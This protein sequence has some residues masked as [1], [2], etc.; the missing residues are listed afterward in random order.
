MYLLMADGEQGSGE[1]WIATYSDDECALT[2]SSRILAAVLV[3][4]S[5]WIEEWWQR[6][7]CYGSHWGAVKPW[8]S[9]GSAPCFPAIPENQP[10]HSCARVPNTGFVPAHGHGDVPGGVVDGSLVLLSEPGGG[11]QGEWPWNVKSQSL[12]CTGSREC[13][14]V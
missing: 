6:R 11:W 9:C 2:V 3:L 5:P 1:K 7:C 10:T 4:S 13:L 12:T 14:I 8:L